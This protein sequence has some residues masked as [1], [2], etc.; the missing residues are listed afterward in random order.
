MTTRPPHPPPDPYKLAELLVDDPLL[1]VA[2]A[3]R[4][5]RHIEARERT[6]LRPAPTA[7]HD[8]RRPPALDDR[9][10]RHEV[11]GGRAA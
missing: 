9:G 11:G 1:T 2:E 5:L 10:A 7:P 4:K 3:V 6:D 8:H